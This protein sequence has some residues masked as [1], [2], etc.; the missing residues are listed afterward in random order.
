[1]AS[2]NDEELFYLTSLCCR[3]FDQLGFGFNEKVYQ[4][5]LA[6]ELQY[7]FP[8]VETEFCI[9]QFYITSAGEKIQ[10][11]VLKV[12]IWIPSAKILIELKTVSRELNKYSKE[13]NQLERYSKILPCF[14]KYLINFSCEK[15]YIICDKI[16]SNNNN[17]A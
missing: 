10:L 11:T 8:T 17:Q 2:E 3:I 9:P 5:A 16:E 14:S 6:R 12:D 1:M 15:V 4:K 13:W 7:R